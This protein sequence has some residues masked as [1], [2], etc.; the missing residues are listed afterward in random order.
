M[1]L[2]SRKNLLLLYLRSPKAWNDC[3]TAMKEWR[4]NKATK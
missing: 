2:D 3:A 1:T 4:A